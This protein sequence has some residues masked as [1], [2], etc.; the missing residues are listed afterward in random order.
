[1]VTVLIDRLPRDWDCTDLYQLVHPFCPSHIYM[2][3]SDCV[4]SL[5]FAFVFFLDEQSANKAV[6]ALGPCD[7]SGEQLHVTRTVAPRVPGEVTG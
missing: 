1:M 4:K 5:G 2:A 6:R 7:I 3:A